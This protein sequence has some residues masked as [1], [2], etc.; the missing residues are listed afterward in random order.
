MSQLSASYPTIKPS[1]NL[2]F[3]RTKTLD[4]RV[5]FARASTATF[6]DG[7]TVAKAEE[8][9]FT[10]STTISNVGGGAVNNGD[11]TYSFSAAT[12]WV[13]KTLNVSIE[14]GVQ[15]TVSCD[16]S[17]TGEVRLTGLNGSGIAIGSD[18]VVT[19]TAT[20]TRYSW[21]GTNNLTG[22][23]VGL[24]VRGAAG[25]TAATVRPEKF[26][27]EFRSAAT[28]YTATTTQA[29]TNYIPV[30]RTAA[31]GVARFDHNPTTG[32][33]L[34][35][36]IEEQRANLTNYSDQFDNAYW[37][38][39][40]A[41]IT[42]NTIIAPDGT[43]SG[44]KISAT[45]AN[46]AHV[47]FKQTL[48]SSG[49]ISISVYAKAGEY[50]W[51]FLSDTLSTNTGAYFNLSTGALG[52][53]GVSAS[54]SIT[55]VGNGWYR[56]T[57]VVTAAAG[58]GIGVYAAS[59]NN[60]ITFTGDGYSGIFIWGAQLEVGAFPTSYIPTVASSVTRSADSASMTGTNFSSWFNNGEGTIFTSGFVPSSPPSGASDVFTMTNGTTNNRIRTV[61]G[62]T[63]VR[64]QVISSGATQADMFLATTFPVAFATALAYKVND[65]AFV[66]NG[67]TVALDT[68]GLVSV[69]NEVGIGNQLNGGYLNGTI[70]K[71]AYY[72][73]R[74][75][76]AQLQTL[77]T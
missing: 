53:V 28:A 76:N 75:T 70:R 63:S 34:G 16:L 8:N 68:V 73:A 71:I 60:T 15:F 77:T 62:S 30:L 31:A 1:L 37:S 42:A 20:P 35:L 13:F 22:V 21:T 27:L 47:A 2:D 59:A 67:G 52:T 66:L 6:Y 9:Q 29:I 43:L 18:I 65:F 61:V 72:P 44:D 24:L 17:G 38:K 57:V 4:P 36:L 55:G 19:L 50:G 39:S 11:G 69:V 51:L 32:E 40:N 74:L 23:N 12:H 3:A 7:V 45:T 46:G 25:G 48:A 5:T 26:Q 64:G 54:A 58:S 49:S 56:C 10:S 14:S 33:S 41:T